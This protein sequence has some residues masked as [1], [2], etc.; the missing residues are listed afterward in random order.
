MV[1][2]ALIRPTTISCSRAGWLIGSRRVSN[3]VPVMA[4]FTSARARPE[5]GFVRVTAGPLRM[6]QHARTEAATRPRGRA[7]RP[8]RKDVPKNCSDSALRHEQ[9]APFGR[10]GGRKAFENEETDLDDGARGRSGVR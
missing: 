1:R 8:T 7:T 3:G 2:S 10:A 9:S 6:A 5:A 4:F